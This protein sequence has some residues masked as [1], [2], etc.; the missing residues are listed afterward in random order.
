LIPGGP[1]VKNDIAYLPANP[2]SDSSGQIK[3]KESAVKNAKIMFNSITQM[4]AAFD[5]MFTFTIR[6]HLDLLTAGIVYPFDPKNGVGDLHRLPFG[7]R[8]PLWVK[9]NIKSP[10]DQKTPFFYTGL[11]NVVSI[12]NHFSGGKFIQTLAVLM[13]GGMES[14]ATLKSINDTAPAST[15]TI[16]PDKAAQIKAASNNNNLTIL[17]RRAAITSIINAPPSKKI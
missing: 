15:D 11:Y 4:H 6:G 2:Q 9:V 1:G 17:E 10:N 8:S 5:P 12:E 16:T 14:D 7:V 13:M 3:Y